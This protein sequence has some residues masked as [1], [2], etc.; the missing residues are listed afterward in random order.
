MEFVWWALTTLVGGFVGFFLAGYLKRKGENLA[1][2]EDIDK[3]VQQVATVTTTTKEIEEK[4]S[5]EFWGHR[6]KWE[7]RKEALF[8]VVKEIGT[9]Q[10]VIGRTAG[11]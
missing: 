2:H 1:T 7:I 4:I 11:A 10:N 8:E 9:L 3:L 5:N 6:K